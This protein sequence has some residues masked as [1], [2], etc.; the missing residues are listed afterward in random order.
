[1]DPARCPDVR[2]G[3]LRIRR[4]GTGH[5]C[6]PAAGRAVRFRTERGHGA[7][8]LRRPAR[9]AT[10]PSGRQRPGRFHHHQSRRWLPRG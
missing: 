1:M 4:H 2:P 5:G 9:A 7:I 10:A 8:P 3:R 6:P